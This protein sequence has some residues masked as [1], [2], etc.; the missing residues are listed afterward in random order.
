[1]NRDN[2][3]S[4]I[5]VPPAA[6][7]STVSVEGNQVHA[8]LATGES[9][10]VSLAGATVISWKLANGSEQ[11]W[12]SDKAVLD[13]S[14]AIRG[15]IPIVFPVFGPPPKDR[16]AVASLPQHGFARNSTWEFLGKTS[17]SDNSVKLDF[18][19]SPNMISETFKKSWPYDFGL[20]YSVTLTPEALRTSLNVQNNG[21]D[22]FE[23]QVLLHSYFKVKD[24]SEVRVRNLQNA[25]KVDK[26]R[27]GSTQTETDAEVAIAGEVDR[28]YTNVD[29]KKPV[30]IASTPSNNSLFTIERE[31]MGDVVVWNPWIDKANGMGDFE[32]KDGYKN[33]VCVEAGAVDG[34]QNLEPGDSWEGGQTIRAK[35]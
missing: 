18:G 3:P 22:S 35:L 7:Q 12:L 34:W 31:S 13:G 5:G 20:V 8:K 10:V 9:V 4:A 19:L 27:G 33:M 24:I 11:L 23:F 28:L 14:K 16:A 17:E 2:K 26:T 21:K 29:V 32:P 15:G 25:V 6:A 30:I 1:M